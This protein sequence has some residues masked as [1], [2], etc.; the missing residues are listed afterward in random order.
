M[1]D[2]Q[3]IQLRQP[4]VRMALAAEL[5]KAEDDR[6]DGALERST[7]QAQTL[8]T[9]YRAALQLH[10]DSAQPDRVDTAEGLELAELRSRADFGEYI[11]APMA[12]RGVIAGPE[13]EYNQELGL[14]EDYFPLE[15]L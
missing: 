7:K 15:V 8:E 10:E 12:G 1:T 5:D 13:L 4:E 2:L 6:E 9:E 11:A 14:R 3:R